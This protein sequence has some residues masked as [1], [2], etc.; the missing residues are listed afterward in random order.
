MTKHNAAN[1]RVKN[2][3]FKLL[4]E[5]RGY[6]ETSIDQNTAQQLLELAEQLV[7][8]LVVLPG[9]MAELKS[10]IATAP[11]PMRRGMTAA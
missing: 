8:Y 6:D 1:E 9:T 10:R 11:V 7:A 2:D 4:K 3:Y 5:A